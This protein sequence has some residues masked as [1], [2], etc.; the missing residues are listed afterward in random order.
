MSESKKV[1]EY[2]TPEK[3]AE[4]AQIRA[5]VEAHL[6]EMRAEARAAIEKARKTGLHRRAALAQ[7][8]GERK[9]QGLSDEEMMARSGLDA[10]VLASMAGRDAQPTIETMETYAKA[11]GKKLLI[12]LADEAP[13]V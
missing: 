9:R 4:H 5:D 10:A 8:R 11:L 2:L 12:V 3:L 6:P 1:A 7:L 13:E